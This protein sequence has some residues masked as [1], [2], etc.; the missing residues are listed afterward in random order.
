[1]PWEEI[2]CKSLDFL[3]LQVREVPLGGILDASILVCASADGNILPPFV[4]F[5]VKK[6]KHYAQLQD[7]FTLKCR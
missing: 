6:T 1:M 2:L 3:V 7:L 4:T 5:K